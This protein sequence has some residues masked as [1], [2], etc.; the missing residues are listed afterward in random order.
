MA[1]RAGRGNYRWIVL[2]VV[3]LADLAFG[4]TATILGAS[5]GEVA[6]DLDASESLVA[7]T[8][9]APF[10][11]VA[12]GTPIFGKLG[13][14]YGLRRVFLLG[15]AAFTGATL[16]SALAPNALI[17][18]L[19]RALAG[20]GASASLPT[21]LAMILRV[22]TV[23]ERPTA[24]GWFHMV[25]TGAPAIGL[26]TGGLLIDAFGW[27][28]VFFVYGAV[29]ALGLLVAALVLRP[30]PGQPGVP[31]DSKGAT[32]LALS[33][34]ALMISITSV[35]ARGLADPVPWVLLL[36]AVAALYA[37]VRVERQTEDPLLPLRYLKKP[38][39]SAPLIES[40]SLN[41]AYLGGLIVTPLILQDVFGLS[42]SAATA[43]LIIRPATFS[44]SSPL[45]GYTTRK[46]GPRFGAQAGSI[47]MI[48]SMSLFTFGALFENM[49]LLLIGLATSGLSLGLE[50]PAV[51]T[52]IANSVDDQD[53][54]VANGVAATSGTLGGVLGLQ[55]FLLILGNADPH[56]AT[57][58]APAYAFGILLGVIG[59]VAA[60][61]MLR[62]TMR[63]R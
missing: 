30:V 19:L 24:L 11:A 51:N 61:A 39:F 49:A 23:P 44:I 62:P 22:F 34:L 53:L 12:I 55:V 46:R 63:K 52:S 42:L 2:G 47:A 15:L 26:V 4:T 50:A 27:E 16:L 58:F 20:L 6:D 1:D 33:T 3:L 56:G 25:A 38:N 29:A 18:V 9:T 28:V 41:A 14:I 45:G 60:S 37:F 31:V 36:V 32:L 43:L 7:W 5:L 59:L 48:A 8:V 54:G 21:G 35:A 13:D 17:L 57:D 10:L 40:A